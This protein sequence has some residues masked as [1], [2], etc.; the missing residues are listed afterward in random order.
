[1]AAI[2]DGQQ[3]VDIED[4]YLVVFDFSCRSLLNSR[5]MVA[6]FVIIRKGMYSKW[7]TKFQVND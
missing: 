4:S 7:L 5:T 6:T 1:M 3:Y 2:H